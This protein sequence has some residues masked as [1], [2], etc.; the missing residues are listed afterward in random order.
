MNRDKAREA[1]WYFLI[2]LQ[3]LK[4][5]HIVWPADWDDDILIITV[6]GT[7]CWIEEPTHPDWSQD[8]SYYSHRYNKAGI[9]Y[10]LG[11]AIACLPLV[12]M[13]GPFKAGSSDGKTFFE[14]GLKDPCFHSKESHWQSWIQWPQ[15]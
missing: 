5:E 6:D 10:E 12:W 1:W 9:N 14:E 11:I 13:N 15:R 3:A 8:K 4:E 2:C 7:H